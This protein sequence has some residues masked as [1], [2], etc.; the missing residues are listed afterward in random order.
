MD[1]DIIELLTTREVT[2]MFKITYR[3]LLRWRVQRNFPSP[4]LKTRPSRYDVNDVKRWIE[5]QRILNEDS[6]SIV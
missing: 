3:T 2:K 6:P 5:Y 4:L 1:N